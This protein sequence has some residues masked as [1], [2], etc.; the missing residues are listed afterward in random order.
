[1]NIIFNRVIGHNFLSISDCDLSLSNNGYAIVDGKNNYIPD[2]A[3]SNGS[4][5]SS[6]FKMSVWALTG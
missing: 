1:M 2:L 5:K 4:G 3:K 6:I